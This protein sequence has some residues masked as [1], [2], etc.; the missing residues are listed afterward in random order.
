M[1]QV[2]DFVVGQ[3]VVSRANYKG[4]GVVAGT[5]GEVVALYPR[6][7]GVRFPRNIM[8]RVFYSD[9]EPYPVRR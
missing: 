1:D 9:L 7:V 2:Q 6:E 4:T 8:V 3:R 5:I